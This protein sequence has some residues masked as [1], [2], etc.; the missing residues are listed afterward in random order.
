MY[1]CLFYLFI[2]FLLIQNLLTEVPRLYLSNTFIRRVKQ[3]CHGHRKITKFLEFFK[4][5]V[6]SGKVMVF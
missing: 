4:F 2:Y 6:I 1:L 5:S 3:G